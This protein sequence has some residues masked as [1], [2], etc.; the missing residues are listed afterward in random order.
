MKKLLLYL[1]VAFFG[2]AIATASAQPRPD[3]GRTPEERAD[4]Q[5]KRLTKH[6]ALS[7]DQTEKVHAIVLERTTKMEALRNEAKAEKGKK[8]SELQ[9]IEAAEEAQ[10]K[11]VL[12]PEQFDKYIKHREEMKKKMQQKR[13]QKRNGEHGAPPPPP[14]D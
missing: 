8:K 5:T 11:Q 14:A 9:A 10:M 12:T 3:E 6:L 4:N 2:L 7:A 1:S 13:Q